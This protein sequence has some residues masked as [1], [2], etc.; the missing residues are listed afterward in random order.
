MSGQ[1]DERL[2]ALFPK[3]GSADA[4][5]EAAAVLLAET[6][7]EELKAEDIGEE[8]GKR[9]SE[10]LNENNVRVENPATEQWEECIRRAMLRAMQDFVEES[11]NVKIVLKK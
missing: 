11:Q 3:L 1:V 2:K 7:E 4:R 6:V 8:V 9:I 10:I 5:R